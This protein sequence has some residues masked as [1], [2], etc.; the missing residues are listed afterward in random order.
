MTNA[1]KLD[2]T[3]DIDTARV[4]FHQSDGAEGHQVVKRQPEGPDQG[5]CGPSQQ[6]L[7][8]HM[9]LL[10]LD[11][12]NSHIGSAAAAAD[13]ADEESQQRLLLPTQSS[14]AAQAA[15]STSG[16]I[17]Y[18]SSAEVASAYADKHDRTVSQLA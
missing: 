9:I 13:G 11:E 17:Q 7:A 1:R 3:L 15:T 18:S 4:W 5:A 6:Q 14:D 10:D 8:E 16:T 12:L 2:R